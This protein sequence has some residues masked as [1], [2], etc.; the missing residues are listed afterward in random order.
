MGVLRSDE[1]F[2]IEKKCTVVV[3]FEGRGNFATLPVSCD[4][5][6]A[7]ATLAAVGMP[8]LLYLQ[9]QRDLEHK[10]NGL[11]G[12]CAYRTTSEKN[13]LDDIVPFG[14]VVDPLY[15]RPVFVFPSSTQQIDQDDI[16]LGNVPN[17]VIVSA[18]EPDGSP[19]EGSD[20]HLLSLPRRSGISLGTSTL[21]QTPVR[22][23][24]D[25]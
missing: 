23:N 25:N 21:N 15:P 12:P 9:R 24:V 1:T 7:K 3:W 10:R 16:D 2:C 5:Y 17:T 14:T 19:A 20:T 11:G 18:T 8:P 22:Q 6:I 13:R 4:T